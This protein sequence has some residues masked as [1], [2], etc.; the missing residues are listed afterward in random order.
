MRRDSYLSRIA[1]AGAGI[2]PALTPSRIL[3]RPGP[4]IARGLE[5]APLR[6]GQETEVTSAVPP[7]RSSSG[8]PD[9]DENESREK[10]VDVPPRQDRFAPTPPPASPGEAHRP[11][12]LSITAAQAK[13]PSPQQATL[14]P[15]KSSEEPVIM[16]MMPTTPPPQI[17]FAPTVPPRWAKW[18]PAELAASTMSEAEQLPSPQAI[19][20]AQPPGLKQSVAADSAST[21]EPRPESARTPGLKHAVAAES[22]HLV[23]PRLEP[24]RQDA[25]RPQPATEAGRKKA[26]AMN[27]DRT[28]LPDAPIL[29][30][31]SKTAPPVLVPSP[32]E[33]RR[34]AGTPGAAEKREDARKIGGGIRIGT[35]EVRVAPPEAVAAPGR[36]PKPAVVSRAALSQGFRSFGLIQS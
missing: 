7:A 26:S 2:G 12:F 36:Q 5:E 35:V 8:K 28:S 14:Q 4:Q 24:A 3:H 11:E 30:P 20:P 15:S 21:V 19:K 22:V 34:F 23:G 27:A 16:P 9:L 32:P 13:R 25:P 18:P 33:R 10:P 1:R 29:Q 17:R 6:E 31:T